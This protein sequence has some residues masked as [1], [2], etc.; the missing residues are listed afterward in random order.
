[1]LADA[2]PQVR[3]GE[4]PTRHEL[5]KT[6]DN[7]QAPPK[8]DEKVPPRPPRLDQRKEVLSACKNNDVEKLNRLIATSASVNFNNPDD[9]SDGETPLHVVCG[10]GHEQLLTVL[11]RQRG[12]Y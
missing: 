11:S 12:Q 3:K 9:E 7:E 1:M 5:S 2:T 10:D 8:S 4:K 6:K